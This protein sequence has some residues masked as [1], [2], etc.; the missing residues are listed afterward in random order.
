MFLVLF[1]FFKQ[2]TAYEMRISDWSSDVCSSDLE[3]DSFAKTV[4]APAVLRFNHQAG[5]DQHGVFILR[6]DGGQPSPVGSRP[7]QAEARRE[8]AGKPALLQIADGRLGLLAFAPIM[9]GRKSKR[10]HSRH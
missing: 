2:K 1:F 3:H 7:A 6:K 5:L 4:V 10:L 8:F 9:R